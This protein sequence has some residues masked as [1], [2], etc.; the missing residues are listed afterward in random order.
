MSLLSDHLVS[1]KE[2]IQRLGTLFINQRSLAFRKEAET[3]PKVKQSELC[4]ETRTQ[5]GQ[6]LLMI[7]CQPT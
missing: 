5:I 3:E 1:V 2:K 4:R 7:L 6:A